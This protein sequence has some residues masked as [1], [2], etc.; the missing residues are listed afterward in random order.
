MPCATSLTNGRGLTVMENPQRNDAPQYPGGM[1][2]LGWI[3][4]FA[5][6]G[7]LLTALY[8]LGRLTF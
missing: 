3:L 2:L 1:I 5:I 8:W 7:V 4:A 6:P